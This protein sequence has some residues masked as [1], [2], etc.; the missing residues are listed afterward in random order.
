MRIISPNREIQAHFERCLSEGT[1]E[2]LSEMFAFGQPPMSN[3]DRE[4]LQG[5]CNGSQF[6]DQP[7]V[8]DMYRKEAQSAGVDITGKVYK[9]SLADY[10]GDP[11]AWVS[12]RHDVQR[13][14]ESKGMSCVGAVRVKAPEPISAPQDAPLADDIVGTKVS[15]ILGGLPEADRPHV[16]T[17]DLAEQVREAL[18]PHWSKPHGT[19]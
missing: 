2:T 17:A 8:G 16:D 15:E 9:S 10:P 19:F 14:A 13:V 7:W 6:E 3:T 4:F 18:S 1:S 12:D 5:F 11:T